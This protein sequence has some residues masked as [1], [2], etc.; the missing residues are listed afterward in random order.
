M[1]DMGSCASKSKTGTVVTSQ[2]M[3]TPNQQQQQQQQQHKSSRKSPEVNVVIPV[4]SRTARNVSA[5][6]TLAASTATTIAAPRSGGHKNYIIE[7]MMETVEEKQEPS[8]VK[9]KTIEVKPVVEKRNAE[10]QG[11]KMFVKIKLPY[12]RLQ[13]TR[14]TSFV[15]KD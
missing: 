5:D 11:E 4:V 2:T 10:T 14:E 6:S 8:P 15:E 3:P 1:R 9:T 12:N 7:N 13:G